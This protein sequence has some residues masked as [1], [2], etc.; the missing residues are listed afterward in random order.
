MEFG[1]EKE[2][3]GKL[4]GSYKVQQQLDKIRPAS[5]QTIEPDDKTLDLDLPVSTPSSQLDPHHEEEEA[6]H[7]H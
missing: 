3:T 4:C 5:G 1:A 2:R 7:G 6:P